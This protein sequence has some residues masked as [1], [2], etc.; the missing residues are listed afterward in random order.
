MTIFI[1]QIAFDL[2]P[3]LSYK[4]A[5]FAFCL[6]TNWAA[7]WKMTKREKEKSTDKFREINDTSLWSLA[8]DALNYGI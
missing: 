1:Y 2:Q 3:V 4:I 6:Q 8:F 5:S 7:S